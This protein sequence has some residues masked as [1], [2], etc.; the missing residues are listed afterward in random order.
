MIFAASP[1]ATPS[2]ISSYQVQLHGLPCPTPALHIAN[3]AKPD[4]V[5]LHWS[6]AYP[7]FDLQS[8]PDLNGAA[9]Y[10]FENVATPPVVVD[11]DYSVTNRTTTPKAFYRLRKP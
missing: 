2:C 10:P 4:E 5:R 11:G 7:Q 1:I 9:P 3:T 8:S 6:T